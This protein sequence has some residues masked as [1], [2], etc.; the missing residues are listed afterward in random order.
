MQI[1]DTTL[2]IT[3]CAVLEKRAH[4]LACNKR[5]ICNFYV[6]DVAVCLSEIAFKFKMS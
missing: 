3:M 4:I 5:E 6:S 1:S 2:G